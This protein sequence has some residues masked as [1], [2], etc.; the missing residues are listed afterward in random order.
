MTIRS[1]VKLS[2]V[3]WPW[4]PAE[5]QFSTTLLIIILI[6]DGTNQDH[7]GD[8]GGNTPPSFL[9]RSAYNTFKSNVFELNYSGSVGSHPPYQQTC[10][11]AESRQRLLLFIGCLWD[12]WFLISDM[13]GPIS[14]YIWLWR[15]EITHI[16]IYMVM[17][18]RNYPYHDRG[19]SPYRTCVTFEWRCLNLGV[20]GEGLKGRCRG[21]EFEG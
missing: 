14:W 6:P 16:V 15:Y 21:W 19:F 3:T 7:K 12:F 13:S 5:Q 10:R 20:G 11:R 4:A 2:G 1:R 8:V 17:E 18:L 9:K